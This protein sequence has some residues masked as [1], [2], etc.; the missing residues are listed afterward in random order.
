MELY[1]HRCKLMATVERHSS[2][3]YFHYST[4]L[5]QHSLTHSFAYVC[6]F[7]LF[8]FYRILHYPSQNA[9]FFSGQWVHNVCLFEGHMSSKIKT[10]HSQ[11]VSFY[12][13]MKNVSFPI[14]WFLHLTYFI[15]SNIYSNYSTHQAVLN[16]HFIFNEGAQ[17]CLH[18][19]TF[20][21]LVWVFYLQFLIN[22]SFC[23]ST[24]PD[25]AK[26]PGIWDTW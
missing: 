12:S 1:I 3:F 6:V 11:F 22:I 13:N 14:A 26:R 10:R 9:F 25:L 21:W 18:V 8:F 4:W 20:V 15:K 16:V 24:D 23:I 17:T 19:L 2:I 5:S 7:V